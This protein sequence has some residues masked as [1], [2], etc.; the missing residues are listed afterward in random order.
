LNDFLVF[1]EIRIY[2]CGVPPPQDILTNLKKIRCGYGLVR[3]TVEVGA[4]KRP[5]LYFFYNFLNSTSMTNL[6]NDNESL[7]KGA[8]MQT[9]L[10]EADFNEMIKDLKDVQDFLTERGIKGAS[11]LLRAE[12]LV[13]I[14]KESEIYK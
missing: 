3:K 13:R 1:D 8:L 2:L 10:S 5:H 6:L 9:R 4:S 11:S 12:T 7:F 14:V